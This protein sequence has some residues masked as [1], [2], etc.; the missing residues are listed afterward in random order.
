MPW[1]FIKSAPRNV[2]YRLRHWSHLCF[3][4]TLKVILRLSKEF[5]GVQYVSWYFVNDLLFVE[6]YPFYVIFCMLLC[7]THNSNSWFARIE[8]NFN[9]TSVFFFFFFYSHIVPIMVTVMNIKPYTLYLIMCVCAANMIVIEKCPD[10]EICGNIWMCMLQ[11]AI[12]QI[13]VKLIKSMF[14]FYMYQYFK[15]NYKLIICNQKIIS[16]HMYYY[17]YVFVAFLSQDSKK[18]LSK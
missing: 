6:V 1:K 15:I 13:I 10:E 9:S 5:S 8:R 16:I 3:Q 12:N 2:D 18:I 4:T 11:Y 17:S 14:D 7:M